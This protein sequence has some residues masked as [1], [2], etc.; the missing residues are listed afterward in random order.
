MTTVLAFLAALFAALSLAL[1][2][3]VALRV[4]KILDPLIEEGVTKSQDRP[5][6]IRPGVRV[7]DAGILTDHKGETFRF[8]AADTTGLW[9]LT[10]L[11]A[12]CPG[13]KQQLPTFKKWVT[14][15]GVSP[16]RVIIMV[17]GEPEGAE[18]YRT[19]LGE[20][21]RITQ[22]DPSSTLAEDIGAEVWPT[23]LVVSEGTVQFSEI[24]ASRLAATQIRLVE[25]PESE[26]A[27]V[28]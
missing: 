18:L 9:L 6:P 25:D 12:G 13:C 5:Q 2:L 14:S 27:L 19:E 1:S 23:Y 10:F 15:L 16:D 11:S 24:S 22:A 4:K 21:A 28:G 3:A 7:P 20:L 26:A 17:S 8:P